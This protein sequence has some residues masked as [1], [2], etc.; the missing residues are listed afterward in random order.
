VEGAWDKERIKNNICS[1]SR[2]YVITNVIVMNA[3]YR[4]DL[5]SNSC[6]NKEVT[7][8]NRKLKKHL[9]I[10]DYSQIVEVDPLKELYRRHGLHVNQNSKEQM[11]KKIVLAVKSMLKKKVT[12][13]VVMFKKPHTDVPD[14]DSKME[15]IPK[16]DATDLSNIQMTTS[17]NG[18]S[19]IRSSTRSKKPP[20]TMLKDFFYGRLPEGMHK[21]NSREN[22]YKASAQYSLKNN[23]PKHKGSKKQK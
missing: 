16:H 19:A 23:T 5:D 7:V 20:N 18:P 6:A 13:P 21:K 1:L 3:P 22:I 9:K 11:A 12:D 2:E 15:T 14:K 8:Y 10:F 17:N 4:H